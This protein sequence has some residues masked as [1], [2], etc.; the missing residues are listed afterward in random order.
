MKSLVSIQGV[1]SGASGATRNQCCQQW[2]ALGDQLYV[3]QWVR[4]G[5]T[6]IKDGNGFAQARR[7][8]AKTEAGINLQR[9]ADGQQRIRSGHSV[10]TGLHPGGRDSTAKKHNVRD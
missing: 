6:G 4:A 10:N 9:A 7:K 1:V 3:S 8:P 5:S 2:R